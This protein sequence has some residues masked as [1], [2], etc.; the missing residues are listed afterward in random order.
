MKPPSKQ[1]KVWQPHYQKNKEVKSMKKDTR[2][3]INSTRKV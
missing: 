1:E 3:E 2:N